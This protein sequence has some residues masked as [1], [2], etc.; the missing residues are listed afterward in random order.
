MTRELASGPIV[1]PAYAGTRIVMLDARRVQWQ[2][3]NSSS[4]HGG[5]GLWTPI[6]MR[7]RPNGGLDAG[8]VLLPDLYQFHPELVSD[9][10]MHH[11][12][13]A[14]N[15]VPMREDI[16][17]RIRTFFDRHDRHDRNAEAP[18]AD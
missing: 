13:L 11:F 4:R 17:E 12:S 3:G 7:I 1:G 9:P 8:A 14:H 16:A 15:W 10:P 5:S 18:G 2:L 6:I